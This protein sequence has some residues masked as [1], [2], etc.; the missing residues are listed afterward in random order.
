VDIFMPAADL[1][2][3]TGRH[4][5]ESRDLASAGKYLTRS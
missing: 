4:V 5:G 3:D 1:Q 2:L